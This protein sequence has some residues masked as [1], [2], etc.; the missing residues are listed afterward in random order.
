VNAGHVGIVAALPEEMAPLRARLAGTRSL[1]IA[2]ALALTG[3]LA[4]RPVALVVTGDGAR[5]AAAGVQS[6]LETLRIERL[7]LIGVAGALT[8]DLPLHAL[9]VASE[10]RGGADTFAA[11]GPA[12]FAA[13]R[14]GARPVTLVTADQIAD[15]PAART[16]LLR[17]HGDPA[18]AA[19]DLESAVLVRAAVR[20]RIPWLAVRAISD[21][22]GEHLPALLNRAREEGGAIQR[23]RVL[24]GLLREPATVATL[25]S[26]RWRVGRCAQ[27]LATA[28]E[29][30]LDTPGERGFAA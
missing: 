23:G 10:V 8:P 15:S 5:N 21:T 27:V 2:A 14:Q 1:P 29:R 25:L 28:T 24:R 12:L 6:L 26:L 18:S 17:E 3:V 9:V 11:D 16:R 20:R 22:A 30:L 13:T 7:L 4:G 19:V